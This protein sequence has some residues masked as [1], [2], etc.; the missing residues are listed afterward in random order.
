MKYLVRFAQVHESFRQAETDSLAELA[1]VQLEWIFY[2]D[3]VCAFRLDMGGLLS[4]CIDVVVSR[5]AAFFKQGTVGQAPAR[6]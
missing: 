4:M 1:G 6:H 3:A 5:I 2:S